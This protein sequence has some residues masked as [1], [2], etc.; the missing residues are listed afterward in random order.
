M[1]YEIAAIGLLKNTPASKASL[2][3]VLVLAQPMSKRLGS[4]LI[5][6]LAGLAK[7]EMSRNGNIL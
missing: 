5:N 3:V 7:L 1:Q 2:G 4:K 6:T